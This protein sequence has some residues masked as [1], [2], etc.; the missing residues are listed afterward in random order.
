[1]A[2]I[3]E[4]I[5]KIA[6]SVYGRDVRGSIVNSLTAI[7]NEVDNTKSATLTE[8]QNMYYDKLTVAPKG[9]W[10]NLANGFQPSS[11][12]YGLSIPVYKCNCNGYVTIRGGIT[13]YEDIV[14]SCAFLD[15][16]NSVITASTVNMSNASIKI[17]NN[18]VTVILNSLSQFSVYTNSLYENHNS[19]NNMLTDILKKVDPVTLNK[20]ITSKKVQ[21]TETSSAYFVTDAS[22][23]VEIYPVKKG[24]RYCATSAM[25]PNPTNHPIIMGDAAYSTD[26]DPIFHTDAT[27]ASACNLDTYFT[28]PFDGFVFINGWSSDIGKYPLLQSCGIEADKI[29]RVADVNAKLAL[30]TA[31]TAKETADKKVECKISGSI[32]KPYDGQFYFEEDPIKKGDVI[33]V[34]RIATVATGNQ[35][36]WLSDSVRNS[37]NVPAQEI[38]LTNHKGTVIAEQ[39]WNGFTV[40]GHG[41]NSKK[42]TYN[43]NKYKINMNAGTV[44]K[45]KIVAA[46]NSSIA[47]KALADYVCDG[48]NDE[49]EINKA[50]EDMKMVCGVVKL[51]QGDFWIDEFKQYDIAGRKEYIGICVHRD[52]FSGSVIDNKNQGGVTIQG[53]S[54]GRPQRTYI[55]V[56]DT[57]FNNVPTNEQPSVIGGGTNKANPVGGGFGAGYA[58]GWGFNINN[59]MVSLT[60]R[61]R[62]FIAVNHQNCYWG[63]MKCCELEIA[64]YG[65]NVVP[66]EGT[67][68][69]RGWAGWSDGSIIGVEDTYAN[70]FRVG[71]QVGGEHVLYLRV[72]TRFNY[73]A[74]TF[75]EY[76]LNPNSGAQIHNITLMECCDEH[77]QMLPQFYN[78]GYSDTPNSNA[79]VGVTF[80][81]FI[82]EYYPLIKGQKIIN[83]REHTP[84]A[85]C[86]RIDYTSEND[87]NT[88]SVTNKFWEDGH[89]KFF[90][91]T[92][93]AHLQMGD[94]VERRRYSPN[95]CQKYWDTD[96]NKELTC[97]DPA[98]KKWADSMGT[99]VP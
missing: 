9:G 66:I 14:K 90:R 15:A 23:M 74:Y 24:V 65:E 91:T 4:E 48:I 58:G 69:H 10:Y 26:F 75:G 64:G 82:I 49:V 80:I 18:A 27:V 35:Y 36:I 16:N 8:I 20:R 59:V 93:Q 84:G 38:P 88:Q 72:G 28:A 89:G 92:N 43:I 11:S 42:Y 55:R 60:K 68:G 54:S 83:A 50:I 22:Y 39:D 19:S 17:P 95:W 73:C 96:V 13:R 52:T 81:D 97:I 47:D 61:D 99:I 86:G 29:A 87:E 5:H 67:V 71:Y 98:S 34:E 3:T 70:G 53:T 33:D 40:W 77:S 32:A 62:K 2:N 79:R 56:R 25:A 7:N 6:N 94:S 57:A 41:D 63:M 85:W 51:C 44:D 37:A 30:T 31:T 78:A 76:A 1:M 45:V 21:K 12:W 46:H